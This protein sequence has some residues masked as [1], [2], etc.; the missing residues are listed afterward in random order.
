MRNYPEE[1]EDW[2]PEDGFDDEETEPND[3]LDD[4]DTS[5]SGC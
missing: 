5:E 3:P 4:V 2:K 1:W